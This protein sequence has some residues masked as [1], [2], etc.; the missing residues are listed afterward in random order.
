[1][2]PRQ[3]PDLG[4]RIVASREH[5]SKRRRCGL[6][7]VATEM[8]NELFDVGLWASHSGQRLGVALEGRSGASHVGTEGVEPS[9]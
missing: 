1:M 5:T 2:L 9:L 8:S 4:E 6:S 3:L 7:G